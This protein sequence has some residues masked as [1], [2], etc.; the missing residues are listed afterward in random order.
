MSDCEQQLEM[1]EQSDDNDAYWARRRLCWGRDERLVWLTRSL[2]RLP[3]KLKSFHSVAWK[4]T[5][6]WC[7]NALSV[8]LNVHALGD[9]NRSRGGEG[10]R[11]ETLDLAQL[12]T[13]A[14]YTLKMKP[15]LQFNGG[16]VSLC[17]QRSQRR[18]FESWDSLLGNCYNGMT[19][20][21]VFTCGRRQPAHYVKTPPVPQQTV[22]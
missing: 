7:K 22:T 16:S 1:K 8:S 17:K 6:L 5:A 3:I 15:L 19:R 4:Q 18:V 12:H 13:P 11:V 21:I 2:I 10:V 20:R 9:I 14:K